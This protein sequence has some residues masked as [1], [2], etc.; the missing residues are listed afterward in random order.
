MSLP[1]PAAVSKPDAERLRLLLCH[2]G[3]FVRDAILQKRAGSSVH[4]LASVSRESM[5]DTI[6]S[7]DEFSEEAIL[8]WF[9]LRWPRD[10]PVEIVAE[11]LD[12]PALCVFPPET[13][14]SETR[15]K[16][17]IDPI[18]GTRGIMYDKRP[19]W[20]LAAVAPQRGPETMLSDLCVAAMTELP[21]RKQWRADQVSAVRGKG[22]RCESVN[23]LTGQ[24]A[25]LE[26]RPSEATHFQHGFA[27]FAK[28]FPAA[29]MVTAGIEEELWAGL[30]SGQAEPPVIFD[31]QYISTGGQFY[32]LL[33]AH[34]RMIGDFRP[35]LLRAAGLTQVLVCHPY[36]VCTALL[37]AEAGIIFE[38]P[39]GEPV[40]VRLDTTSAVTWVAYA[41]LALAAQVRPI[42]RKILARFESTPE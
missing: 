24:R 16:C 29:K 22:L 36:D 18:D 25:P 41:N 37:L 23:V 21:T 26:L 8:E 39:N 12:D 32:E 20:V 15:W 34:D 9:H 40:N 11:G 4:Q 31:D 38:Q 10:W 42:L 14:L 3:D 28:F 2:L 13:P 1:D 30:Y 33:A 35:I 6:Y 19:A 7:I 27:G 17:I 5:A